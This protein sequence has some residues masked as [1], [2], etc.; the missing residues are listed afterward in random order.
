MLTSSLVLAHA[1]GSPESSARW[2]R[3]RRYQ[4]APRARR[5]AGNAA[6]AAASWAPPLSL[7]FSLPV[8]CHLLP[9]RASPTA[10]AYAR[11]HSSGPHWH[12][13]ATAATGVVGGEQ[14]RG[15]PRERDEAKPAGE[16]FKPSTAGRVEH[17]RL[18]ERASAIVGPVTSR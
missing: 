18:A 13:S 10:R 1:T 8:P 5:D 16:V 6:P 11:V 12:G 15:A 3:V 9:L 7:L 17:R 2:P 14:Q 4:I